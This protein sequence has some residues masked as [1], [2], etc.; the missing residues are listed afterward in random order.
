[1][2]YKVLIEDYA[3]GPARFREAVT[4]LTAAQL[5]LFATE[6]VSARDSAV[7]LTTAG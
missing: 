1:M 5:A 4:G 2:P 6:L 3:T 7:R